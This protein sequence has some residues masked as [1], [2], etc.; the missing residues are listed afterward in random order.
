MTIPNTEGNFMLLGHRGFRGALENTLPAFRRAL[1]Y[2]DG[3]EF[4]V[5]LTG[6]GK[7]VVLHDGEFR[8]NGKLHRV[9]DLTY[10]EL[11]RLHPMGRLIPRVGDVIKLSPNV[12]NADIKD[13][14]VV[15]KLIEKLEGRHLLD[16]TV[17]STDNPKLVPKILRKCPDCRVGFSITS[18]RNLSTSLR[19]MRG[20]YSIHVPLDLVSYI[21]MGGLLTLIELYRRRNLKIWL[22]NYRMDELALLPELMDRADAVIADDPARVKRFIS[23]EP[24]GIEATS[25]VG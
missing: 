6:D 10:R 17:I 22:W 8:A 2:A 5:R 15:E 7:L 25:Y 11:L 1:K 24:I 19:S 20:I 9:R 23:P 3:I 14:E 18:A 4:D 12:L 13:S 16:R 21:G